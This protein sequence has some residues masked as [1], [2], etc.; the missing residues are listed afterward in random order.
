MGRSNLGQDGEKP[1]LPN[2]AMRRI[3]EISAKS[4]NQNRKVLSYL[5]CRDVSLQCRSLMNIYY[6]RY[7]GFVIQ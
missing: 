6:R 7:D 1:N 2:N 5:N 4:F 3:S